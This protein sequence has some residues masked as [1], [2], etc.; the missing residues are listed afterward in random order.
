MSKIL[1]ILAQESCDVILKTNLDNT[2]TT[3]NHPPLNK[4]AEALTPLVF[5]YN[6]GIDAGHIIAKPPHTK[7][8]TTHHILGQ[9]TTVKI[10]ND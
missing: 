3:R 9:L 6:G 7:P 1:E 2:K 4:G 8:Y 10:S 5:Q